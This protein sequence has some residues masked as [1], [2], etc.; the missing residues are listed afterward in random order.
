MNSKNTIIGAVVL[1]AVIIGGYFLLNKEPAPT[2][3]IKIGIIAPL[4]GDAAELGEHI[5]R[6]L[7]IS[8]ESLKNKYSL[9]FE[10]D[11]CFDT[12]AASSIAQKFINNDKL[13]YVIGPLCAPA[14]QAVSGL[15]NQNKISFV[16]T[17]AVTQPFIDSAGNFGVPGLSTYLTQEDSYLAD[18]I[19][20]VLGIN[21]MAV[22]VWNEEWAVEHR[23]GFVERFTELGGQI[24]FDQK[25]N[26]DDADFRTEILK[27]K[28]SGAKGVFIVALNFQN[29]NIVKQIKELGVDIKVFGQFEIE[30]TVFLSHA[31][32]GAE[33][34]S[35][36][37]PKIDTTR[38]ETKDFINNYMNR[39]GTPPNYYAYIGYDALKLYDWAI[40][41][42]NGGDSECVTKQI[43]SV[44]NFLGV[45]GLISFNSDKTLSREFIIKEIKDGQF[46]EVQ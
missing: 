5:Q 22:F 20:N 3:M 35:Y 34:V 29:G 30:D 41:K 11:K 31:G 38:K 21:K 8:N 40:P 25:F 17:S 18:Y 15:F 23:N 32:D 12:K 9:V 13:K 6:G 16:H 19:Y 39:Y 43:L 1:A 26:L 27:I 37:Y 4:T 44:K 24:V 28:N 42:C 10:D 2:E 33:G 36:V 45:S 14:Y 7:M 46:V